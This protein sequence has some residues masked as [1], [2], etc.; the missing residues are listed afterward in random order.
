MSKVLDQLA[1]HEGFRGNYYQCTSNKKT[2]GIGRNVDAKPFTSEEIDYL[3]R[4]NFDGKPMTL[5][6]AKWLLARD[7]DRCDFQ[8]L[9]SHAIKG[10][11][12]FNEARRAVFTNMV[13]NM[14]ITG[15]CKFKN[16]LKAINNH[17]YE[18]A[19]EEMLDSRW[20][21][22]VGNRANQLSKQMATGEFYDG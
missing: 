19:S 8:L 17:D 2:I 11:S 13:Y 15:F 6:E 18:A 20:A 7:V 12:A 22:Q 1:Q 10:V 14:G 21:R 3:G 9:T 5:D 4:T 16:M